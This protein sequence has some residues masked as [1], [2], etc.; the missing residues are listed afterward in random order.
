MGM[1]CA[2]AGRAVATE[3]L[4]QSRGGHPP[5]PASGGTCDE[6]LHARVLQDAG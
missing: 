1:F 2:M 4:A 6:R 5:K 3:V